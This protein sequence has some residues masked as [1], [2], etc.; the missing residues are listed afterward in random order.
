MKQQHS[1]SESVQ[2]AAADWFAKEQRGPLSAADEAALQQWLQSS[3]EHQLAYA[4]CRHLWLMAKA[5]GGMPEMAMELR[6]TRRLA[7]S[8]RNSARIWRHLGQVAAVGLVGLTCWFALQQFGAGNY[9]TAIGEQ[10]LVRLDDESRIMLNTNS[11][12]RVRYNDEQRLIYLERGEAFFTVAKNPERPFIVN[13]RDSQVQALGTAFNVALST[14]TINVA[15]T[16][17][18]V[19]VSTQ[20]AGPSLQTIAELK[21]GQGLSYRATQARAIPVQVDLEKVTAWQAHK[22]LFD[23]ARLADA[24]AEHNRYTEQ[25]IVLVDNN[26]RDQR[27]SGVFNIGDTDSLIFALKTTFDAR[28]Q[29]KPDRILVL[30]ADSAITP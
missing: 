15:V 12:V 11:R 6:A 26:L 19:E 17:G 22:L 2:A 4:Q 16:E 28:V 23:N 18:V 30:P 20:G 10:Q 1:S 14:D 13:V 7:K 25:H 24:I 9:E 21:P 27:I 8:P 5:L 3:A 29:V